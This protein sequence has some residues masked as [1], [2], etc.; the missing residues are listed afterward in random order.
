MNEEPQA[1]GADV[2]IVLRSDSRFP[3]VRG[4]PAD[5][6]RDGRAMQASE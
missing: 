3:A 6:E 5:G 4:E 1:I 2:S